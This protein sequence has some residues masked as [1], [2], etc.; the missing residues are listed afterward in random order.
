VKGKIKETVGT[1]T[2]DAD[3]EAEG[4]AE[5]KVGNVQEWLGRGEKA[6]GA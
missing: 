5:K 6:V 3:L 4:N 1:A 2:N